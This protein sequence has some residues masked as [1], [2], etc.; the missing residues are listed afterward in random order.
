MSQMIASGM[1]DHD[2]KE[3][4][5]HPEMNMLFYLPGFDPCKNPSC[6]MHACDQGIFKK[7]LSLIV[8]HLKTERV[9]VVRE[10]ERR[11][12]MHFIVIITNTL[13]QMVRSVSVPKF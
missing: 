4:S 3:H 7:L 8:E 13:S 2:C 6:R 11:Y 9:A 10:F 12:L 1:S 5:I